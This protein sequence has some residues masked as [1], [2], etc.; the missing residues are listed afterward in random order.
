MIFGKKEDTLKK[1]SDPLISSYGVKVKAIQ[2]DFGRC[3][4]P[5]FFEIS[6]SR[7]KD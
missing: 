4:K 2:A 5:E 1:V 7:L 6:T 3:I